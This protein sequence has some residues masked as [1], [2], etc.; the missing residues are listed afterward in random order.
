MFV[1]M[2]RSSKREKDSCADVEVK[3]DELNGR[4]D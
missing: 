2:Q 3:N 1:G 4:A